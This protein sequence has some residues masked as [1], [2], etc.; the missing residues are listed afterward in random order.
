V[1]KR[2]HKKA[3]RRRSSRRFATLAGFAA[4][5]VQVYG[6]Q[7]GPGPLQPPPLPGRGGG[8]GSLI[9]KLG[10]LAAAGAA[11]WWLLRKFVFKGS[12]DG[13][14]GDWIREGMPEQCPPGLSL[15]YRNRGGRKVAMCE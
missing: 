11:G 9:L 8:R 12:V 5:P 2:K 10:G 14:G 15:R 1:A 6:P 7:S 3:S 13:L 4:A